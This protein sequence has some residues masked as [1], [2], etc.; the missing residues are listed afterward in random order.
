MEIEQQLPKEKWKLN[1]K[2]K[3]I[4]TNKSQQLLNCKYMKNDEKKHIDNKSTP[5]VSTLLKQERKE[6]Q[7]NHQPK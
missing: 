1:N 3:K 4:F 6:N 5:P 7:E 2:I